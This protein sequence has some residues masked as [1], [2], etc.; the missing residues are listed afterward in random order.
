MG[1]V[2]HSQ[3]VNWFEVART[4]W[5]RQLGMSFRQIEERGLMLPVIG[6]NVHYHASTR[7]DDA[8]IVETSVKNYDT[9]KLSFNYQIFREADGKLLVDGSSLHCWTDDRMHPISLRK[10]D[11]ELNQLLSQESG[12]S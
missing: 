12:H 2:H 9:I 10:K 5:V 7:F 8:V 6:I 3:Y 11:P 1:I 4:D